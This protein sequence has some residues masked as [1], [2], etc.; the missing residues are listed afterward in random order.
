MTG[1]SWRV[2]LAGCHRMLA[3]DPGSHNLAAAFAAVPGVQVEAIFDLGE[4]TRADFVECWRPLWGEVATYDNYQRMLEEVAPDLLCIATRQTKH[5]EQIEAA[6]AAGVKGILC[7]KPLATTLEEMDRIVEA[8][9][10]TP[11]LL[12][13]E[14]RW[15]ARY[16]F[17]RQCIADGTIGRVTAITVYG[18]PNLINHG[19]H[20]YDAVLGLV[21]DV[22]PVWVSGLVDDIAAEPPDSR[23][24]MD[25]PGKAQIGL[26]DGTVIYITSAGKHTHVRGT[27]SFDIAGEEGR[28]WV[29]DDAQECYLWS[30]AQE[31]DRLHRLQM[32]QEE[33]DWPTGR[34]MV[35]DLVQALETG[36]RT[37]CDVHEARRATEIGFAVHLSSAAGGKKIE[38]PAVDRALRIESFPWGNE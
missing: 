6:V 23:V 34:A 5:A 31:E 28:L 32:P 20:W 29:L 8:C 14:R 36:G 7:D 18:L 22:E 2:A 19:C 26:A 25:P 16:R 24:H 12:A 9:A 3:P 21:G 37:A 30:G 38:L 35:Q 33:G 10:E 27:L 15:M 13:L 1:K 11:L 17:L 4:E